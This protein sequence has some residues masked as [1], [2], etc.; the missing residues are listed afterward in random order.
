MEVFEKNKFKNRLEWM[1]EW[2]LEKKNNL[3]TR[4][5]LKNYLIKLTKSWVG[6]GRHWKSG[7]K[8]V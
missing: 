8:I 5:T 6:N 4:Q 7:L 2:I 1:D 3:I